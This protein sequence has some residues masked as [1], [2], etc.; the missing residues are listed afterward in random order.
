[1]MLSQQAV[2]EFTRRLADRTITMVGVRVLFAMLT[3]MDFEN[4]VDRSQKELAIELDLAQSDLSRACRLL[5]ECGFVERTAN[6]RGWYRISPRLCW[7]GSVKTL[8]TEI[9]RRATV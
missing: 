7:K 3:H 9:D 6:R 2:G 1:M 8:Q 5:V 4:R